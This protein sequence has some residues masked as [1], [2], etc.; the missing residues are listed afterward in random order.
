MGERKKERN[1]YMLCYLKVIAGFELY[2]YTY[3]LKT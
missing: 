3:L 2:V 1:D